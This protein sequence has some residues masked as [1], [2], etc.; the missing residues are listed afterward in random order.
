MRR[1]YRWRDGGVALLCLAPSALLFAAFVF[2]PLV[3]S[4]QLSFFA[5]DLLGQPQSFVGLEQYATLVTDPYFLDVL[6]TTAYFVALT[7]V[8]GIAIGLGL[9]MLVQIRMRGIGVFRALLATPFA[10][11]AAAAAV[12]FDVLY[13]PSIGL[14]NGLLYYAGTAQVE[15]L[16][17]PALALPSVAAVSVWRYSGYTM[18]VCLAGLQS[19]PES[20]YEAARIDGANARAQFRY[21]SFPLLT[22]TLLFLVVVSTINSLQTFGEIKIM[23]QGGPANATTTLVYS[24]YKTAFGSGTSDFGLASAQGVTLMLVVLCI[25]LVQFRVLGKRTYYR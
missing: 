19:I 22:P 8:P 5:N 4:V 15:W 17:S 2:Y 23:T 1:R 24:L 14:L 6:A 3:R 7:V 10:F 20:L 18:L 16:T 12:V 13:R 25:T 21:I 9:A 11:S